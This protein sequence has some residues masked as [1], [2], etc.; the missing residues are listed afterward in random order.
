MISWKHPF[1]R[2]NEE[3]EMTKKKKEALDNLLSSG[4]ISQ[5]T[6]DLFN[7]KIDEAVAEIEK[8]Q[9]ALLNKMNSKVEEVEQHTKTL[10]LLLANFEIKHVTGEIDE[11]VYQR[12]ISILS[13]GLEAAR[14][15]LDT[16]KEAINQL[17]SSIPAPTTDTVEPQAE[18]QP[19]EN[20][21]LPQPEI[22]IT[23]ETSSAVE[24]EKTPE[25]N[26]E[27]NLPEPPTEPV[28]SSDEGSFQNEEETQETEQQT[29]EETQ[30]TETT[31]EGEENQE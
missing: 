9:R 30:S 3:Y 16:A 5:S 11:D 1:E 19:T 22:E 10:E 28:E 18:I 8:Q 20:V 27:Q 7:T 21:E 2:L 17:S 26:V 14:Q 29:E 12:E 6:Y 24:F 4:K 15:E 13:T 31:I 23:E 25:E